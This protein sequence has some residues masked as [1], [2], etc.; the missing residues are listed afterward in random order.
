MSQ[1]DTSSL[2]DE[3]AINKFSEDLSNPIKYLNS[4]QKEKVINFFKPYFANKTHC[5]ILSF[6]YTRTVENLLADKKK[7]G[8]AFYSKDLDCIYE[9]ICHTHG[10]VDNLIL[11]VNDTNQISNPSFAKNVDVEDYL[12]KPKMNA[13]LGH[14]KDS[15][16]QEV[17]K[18]ADL[19]CLFGISLGETDGLWWKHLGESLK[20]NVQLI[21]FVYNPNDF[22]G[23]ARYLGKQIRDWKNK[24]M[25]ACQIDDSSRN[26][27]SGKIQV[28][29]NSNMFHLKSPTKLVKQETTPKWR[30]LKD[31]KTFDD[32][33]LNQIYEEV[34]SEM[35]QLSYESLTPLAY[36]TYVFA[37]WDEKGI[38]PLDDDIVDVLRKGYKSILSKKE[39]REDL[40]DAKLDFCKDVK[41]L[42]PY[43]DVYKSLESLFSIFNV[44]YNEEWSKKSDKMTYA[45]S[46]LTDKNVKDLFDIEEK[47]LPDHSKSYA[48][49]SIFTEVNIPILVESIKNLGNSG[50]NLFSEFLTG[51]YQLKYVLSESMN[52][53]HEFDGDKAPLQQ[54][55]DLLEETI[56]NLDPKDSKTYRILIRVLEFSIKRI[57]GE[58]KIMNV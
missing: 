16:A 41:S 1:I 52:K 24:L 13:N 46:H 42:K 25:T 38:K 12:L 5:Y 36:I 6:N 14:L 58:T 22:L 35:R 23:E 34:V 47:S 19:I 57:D 28:V 2:V 53:N 31:F 56:A 21:Y 43:G 40:Y 3:Y 49:S 50:R 7:I 44:I 37:Y 48:W 15:K 51:R 30:L 18:K 4:A 10:E 29:F 33:K 45:L 17:I 27:V 11:G 26:S 9:G 54:L 8:N 20:T 32:D 39:Y 55:K